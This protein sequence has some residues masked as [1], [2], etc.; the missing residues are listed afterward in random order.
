VKNSVL[1]KVLLAF[2]LCVLVTGLS[3]RS[4]WAGVNDTLGIGAKAT[5]LGQAFTAYADDFS[6]VHYNPAGLVQM[7]GL[8]VTA[9]LHVCDVDYKQQIRQKDFRYGPDP[10]SGKTT[11]NNDDLI[12]APHTGIVYRP[13][14]ARWSLALAAYGPFGAHVWFDDDDANRYSGAEVY[15]DRIIYAAPTAAYQILDNLSLGVSLGMGYSD[16]GGILRLRVPG[17][18]NAVNQFAGVPLLPKGFGYATDLGKLDFDLN[19]DFSLSVNV[20]LLWEIT[21]WI[22]FGLTYRSES[23]SHMKGTAT[24]ETTPVIQGLIK[25]VT[26]QDVPKYATFGTHLHFIHPQ[27][28]SAGLKVDATSKWRFMFDLV[29]TDWSVRD[30]EVWVHD[31]GEDGGYPP[32]LVL[33]NM[34][35]SG[36]PVDRIIIP[37][38]WEDTIEPHF[39][40]EYQAL[41]W[42]ALRLGYHYRPN[43]ID[44]DNWDNNW[45]LI[46]YHVFSLGSGIKYR[47]WII[48][49][50]Y[51][52]AWAPDW[53]I[54]N[55]ESKN[56]TQGLP[57]G[58]MVYS[59][60]FGD[61][62]DVD[63]EI[64][65]FMITATY[66]F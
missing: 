47:N 1:V 59:P 40:A 43:S 23:S 66:R 9:G 56:L 33:T 58:E 7:E 32:F 63:T 29:W 8:N 2:F 46:E 3:M 42:L 27:S 55:G 21:D 44:Q 41:D 45:P 36:E 50:A 4:S 16:E 17:L 38:E 14:G 54:D 37:R 5:A 11:R 57:H 15:N 34:L 6:A 13:A 64:H 53:E 60:Y 49:M 26:G 31:P 20:G 18:E 65:N 35:G 61:E 62:V 52:L 39:G 22:T 28:V 10:E 24:Y 25:Q 30:N 51:S 48:D 12:Y 19:D